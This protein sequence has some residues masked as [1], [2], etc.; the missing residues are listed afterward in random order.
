MR[1]S[2]TTETKHLRSFQVLEIMRNLLGVR[3]PGQLKRVGRLMTGPE[4]AGSRSVL[5][6]AL[7]F[8]IYSYLSL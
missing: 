7:T 3:K 1:R 6:F 2:V 4:V 5:V 8:T